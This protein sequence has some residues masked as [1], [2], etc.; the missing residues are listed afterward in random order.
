M[1]NDARL[2]FPATGRNAEPILAVLKDVLPATGTV[3]EVASGSG[4][5]VARFASEFPTLHWQPTD[6]DA[7]HRRSIEAWT[8][9]IENVDQPIALDAS[10]KPWPVEQADAIICV[11]MIHIAPWSAGLGLLAGAGRIL[12]PGAP[13]YLYGPYMIDGAHTADS[14]AQFDASLKSRDPAW[15]LRDLG[16]VTRVAAEHGLHLDKTV[17]MP[18]N[19]FSVVFRKAG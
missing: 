4:Q 15:G 3:L 14:N 17:P 6:L 2:D 12:E 19:N 5:H 10:A 18:A 11:N 7:E 16:D 13:L 1:S 9:D 8:A